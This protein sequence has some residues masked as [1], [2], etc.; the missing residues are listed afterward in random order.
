MSKLNMASS[1]VCPGSPTKKSEASAKNCGAIKC[2]EL[3][4]KVT[5]LLGGNQKGSHVGHEFPAVPGSPVLP[6]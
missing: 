2:Q 4:V 5:F 6:L 3:L 1:S